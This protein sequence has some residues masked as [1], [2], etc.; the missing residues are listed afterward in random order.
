MATLSQRPLTWTW[1]SSSRLLLLTSAPGAFW[2]PSEAVCSV[3]SGRP[4]GWG[5]DLAKGG[6][7]EE[8]VEAGK[9]IAEEEEEEGR[10]LPPREKE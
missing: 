7:D 3:L 10:R 9:G 6:G 5:R 1:L 4:M 2:K 8:E